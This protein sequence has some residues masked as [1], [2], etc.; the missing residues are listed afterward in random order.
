MSQILIPT[1]NN[2]STSK[3]VCAGNNEISILTR[4]RRGKR[5]GIR[6]PSSSPEKAEFYR[7][8]SRED[9]G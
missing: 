3:S 6:F 9:R 2:M 1:D 8:W 4:D 7:T 5:L